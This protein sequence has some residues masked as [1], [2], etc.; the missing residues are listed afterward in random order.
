MWVPMGQRRAEDR[1]E[2]EFAAVLPVDRSI[3]IVY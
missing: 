1:A 3:R 2:A